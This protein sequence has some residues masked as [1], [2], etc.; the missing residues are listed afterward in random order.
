MPPPVSNDMILGSV[1]QLRADIGTWRKE[2]ND[3]ID[4]VCS[5]VGQ[6]EADRKAEAAVAKERAFVAA[7]DEHQHA[8]LAVEERHEMAAKDETNLL[9]R[10]W[11]ITVAVAA[12][13]SAGSLALGVLNF[14]VGH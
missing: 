12:A 8:A 10:H 7:R 3:K 5:Q 9:T 1:T 11:R 2:T 13:F 4:G 14:V 6:I